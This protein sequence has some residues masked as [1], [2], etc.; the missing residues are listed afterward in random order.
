MQ[1]PV[2]PAVTADG[3]SDDDAAVREAGSIVAAFGFFGVVW[4]NTKLVAERRYGPL[5]DFIELGQP[6]TTSLTPLLGLESEILSL[7]ERPGRVLELPAIAVLGSSGPQGKINFT[8]FWNETRNIPMALAYRS[9]SQTEM[10]LELSKQIRARLIAE[11]EVSAKSKEL[12]RANSDLESFA[13]IISH[14]LKAP[15]RHMKILAQTLIEAAPPGTADN[16]KARL[17]AIAEQAQRMSK[18]LTELFDYS[19]LGRK[20]EAVERVD[21]RA[22]IEAMA[23]SFDTRAIRISITGRWPVLTTLR[24]P[25]EIVLRNLISNA[26]SHHDRQ[27]GTVEVNG[28]D[29]QLYFTVK[30][31]DDGPGID[32]RHHDSI[33]LPFRTLAPASVQSSGMGLAVVKRTLETVGASIGIESDPQ[34]R[35]GTAFL[36]RWPKHISV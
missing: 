24:A 15:L 31:A 7:R 18:M 20:Y 26:I 19:S 4:M 2:S 10:E 22:L 30:V 27:S 36:I 35:R 3:L 28:S 17:K 34:K 12:A 21:T 9:P 8:F 23:A 11:A 16:D 13:A 6:I 29:D 1:Q 25:M 32:V 33:F 5:V 14:D